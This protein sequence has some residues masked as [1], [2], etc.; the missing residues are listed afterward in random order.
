[1]SSAGDLLGLL[2]SSYLPSHQSMEGN[3]L[4]QFDNM[5]DEL[6]YKF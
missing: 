1:M 2:V 6:P 4:H 5:D 3:E